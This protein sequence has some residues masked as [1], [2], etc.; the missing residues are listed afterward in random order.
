MTDVVGY[1][2]RFVEAGQGETVVLIHG[3]QFGSLYALD[4]WS[5]NLGPL[6][7]RFRVIAF[8]RLGQG[9]TDNPSHPD[10]YLFDR[11]MDHAHAVI[12][13]VSPAPVHVVGHSRGALVAVR[14]AVERPERV[15]SL[16]LV[17]AGAVAPFDPSIPVGQFYAPFDD[18]ALWRDPGRATVVAEPEAQAVDR[19]WITDDYVARLVVIARL[20]RTAE[21]RRILA[22]VHTAWTSSLERYREGSLRVIDEH[23]LA[24]PT[25]VLWGYDDRS[26]PRRSGLRLFER[27]AVRTPDATFKMINGAG[28][29][30]YRDRP[31]AFAAALTA[32]A[33]THSG[34][35]VA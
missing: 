31:T 21:A 29:Y 16:T 9:H 20:E 22:S 17:D 35:G 30:V 2:T 8:D 4:C 15:L 6:A 10:D 24:V 1:Q 26:A 33:T 11:V 5:L 34:G 28:H 25:L 27:I 12:D 19:R 23:G 13:H 7:R 14:V 3:G 18:F 32:F